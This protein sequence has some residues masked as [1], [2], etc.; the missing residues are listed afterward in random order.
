[1]RVGY[2]MLLLPDLGI[3]QGFYLNTLDATE[4]FLQALRHRLPMVPFDPE[5]VVAPGP[6][7]P[8]LRLP[9]EEIGCLTVLASLLVNDAMA[10]SQI[11]ICIAADAIYR[12]TGQPFFWIEGR[13][14]ED[15]LVETSLGLLQ[16]R[17]IQEAQLETEWIGL[18]QGYT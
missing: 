10:G 17:T 16:A 1:M 12:V 6:I 4:P 15:R 13:I 7:F 8:E 14:I 5:N 2:Y 18:E 11:T 3:W 9:E